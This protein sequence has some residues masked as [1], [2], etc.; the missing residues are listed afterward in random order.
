MRSE[1]EESA[2]WCTSSRRQEEY[3]YPWD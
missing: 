3:M 1:N 2:L